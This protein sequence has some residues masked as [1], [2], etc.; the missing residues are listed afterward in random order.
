MVKLQSDRDPRI[1][2]II[3]SLIKNL[4]L[5]LCTF[6]V[7]PKTS[8]LSLDLTVEL[9]ELDCLKGIRNSFNSITIWQ[10]FI[11]SEFDTQLFFLLVYGL[12][13]CFGLVLHLHVLLQESVLEV[14]WTL[15]N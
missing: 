6:L 4:I 1:I 9:L 14:L 10:V 15:E 7:L 5:D 13:L 8:L 12:F 11:C 3:A 2:L